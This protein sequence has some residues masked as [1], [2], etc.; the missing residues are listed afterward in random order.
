MDDKE[1]TESGSPGGN[2]E[3][4]SPAMTSGGDIVAGGAA[5]SVERSVAAINAPAVTVSGTMGGEGGGSGD[6]TMGKKKRGRPRKYESD[7]NLR[8]PYAGSP[9]GGV[10]SLEG[11]NLSPTPASKYSSGTKKGRGRPPD[12]GN[13]QILCSLGELFTATAGRDF[14]PH[15]ITVY[16]GEDVAGK[17]LTFA[18]KGVRGICV[19]SANGSVSNVTIRQPGSSGGILTYEGRF[20]I[21]TLTGSFTFSENGGI[22]SRIGGLSISLAGPDGRVIG[23][24]IAGML[25]AATPIQIVVG[26][27]MPNGYKTPKR[28]QNLESRVSPL[29]HSPPA[30][31]TTATPISQA[32]PEI[33]FPLFPTSQ[34]PVP[35]QGEADNNTN[36][37][38]YQYSTSTVTAN[39]NGTEPSEQRPS[40]DINISVTVD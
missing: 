20:E 10:L 34:L 19:L 7:G 27:F 21:L 4:D 1:S 26:S 2:S 22:K 18:Q 13:W 38:E 25:T 17:I 33:N 14:T 31:M 36:T 35:N 30:T 3:S 5:V 16:T 8:A 40:P 37:K 23:G 32:A 6:L 15:V 9:P 24:G 29:I 11:F 12:S 28:K 39:W